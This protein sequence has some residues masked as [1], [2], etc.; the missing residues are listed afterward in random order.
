MNP[1]PQDK[2]DHTALMWAQEMGHSQVAHFLEQCA[3]HGPGHAISDAPSRA[4]GGSEASTCRVLREVWRHPRVSLSNPSEIMCFQKEVG[5]AST[6][7]PPPPTAQ[8]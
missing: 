6:P 7:N 3:R 2:D 4:M 1:A 5:G 8:T